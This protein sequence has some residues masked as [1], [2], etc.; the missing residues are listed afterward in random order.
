MRKKRCKTFHRGCLE[1][2]YLGTQWVLD[3]FRRNIRPE[4]FP[5]LNSNKMNVKK[6]YYTATAN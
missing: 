4:T 2:Y 5:P 1:H 6:A 3:G